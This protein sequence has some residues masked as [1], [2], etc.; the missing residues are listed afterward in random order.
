MAFAIVTVR[1]ACGCHRAGLTTGGLEEGEASDHLVLI[2]AFNG[3]VEQPSAWQWVVLLESTPELLKEAM[4]VT[5]TKLRK[6]SC[7]A[8]HRPIVRWDQPKLIAGLSVFRGF[9][10]LSFG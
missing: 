9:R 7:R 4:E 6:R 1:F 10:E 2:L 3:R 8:M 5:A